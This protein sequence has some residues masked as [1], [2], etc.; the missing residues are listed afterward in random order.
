MGMH[1]TEIFS[2]R[3]FTVIVIVMLI[4]KSS[5]MMHDLH[6]EFQLV[7]LILQGVQLPNESMET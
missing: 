2:V 6:I 5:E 7:A 4:L 1:W 3:H